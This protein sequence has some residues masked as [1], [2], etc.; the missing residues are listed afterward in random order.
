[1][2]VPQTTL[3]F[4]LLAGAVLGV[5]VDVANGLEDPVQRLVEGVVLSGLV[6]GLSILVRRSFVDSFAAPRDV[7]RSYVAF[8][9]LLSAAGALV[10]DGLGVLLAVMELAFALLLVYAARTVRP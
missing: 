7:G 9:L 1:M 2:A 4:A 10:A 6:L 3:L 5:T 8:V